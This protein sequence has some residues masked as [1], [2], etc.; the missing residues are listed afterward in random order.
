V[1]GLRSGLAPRTG[2]LIRPVRFRLPTSFGLL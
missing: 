2:N 1:S